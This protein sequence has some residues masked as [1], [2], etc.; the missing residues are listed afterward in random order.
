MKN[1]FYLLVMLFFV[2]SIHVSN[3]QEVIEQTQE[4]KSDL[5][6]QA[7]SLNSPNTP[8]NYNEEL[9]SLM[10]KEEYD[11]LCFLKNKLSSLKKIQQNYYRINKIDSDTNIDINE[12]VNKHIFLLQRRIN[13][14][15]K[16]ALKF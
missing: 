9:K 14:L 7:L 8:I 13:E 15:E 3:A 5:T 6:E 1:Y 11:R 4:Y 16:K 12:N 2:L 10:S